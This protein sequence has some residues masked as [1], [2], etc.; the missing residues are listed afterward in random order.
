MQGSF[1]LT[2]VIPTY[3]RAHLIEDTLKSVLNQ[4][5]SDFEVWIIDDGSTDNTAE[6]VSTYLSDRIH[7]HRIENSERGVARNTGTK[8]AKGNYINWLD[9]DDLLLPNHVSEIKQAVIQKHFPDVLVFDYK[10]YFTSIQSYSKSHT[11]PSQINISSKELIKGNFFSCN[12]V[13]VKSAVALNN[14]FNEDRKLSASEDYELWLRLASKYPI[15]GVNIVT[16]V[17][18]HHPERSVFTMKQLDQLENRFN[19]FIDSISNNEDV[20][21]FISDKLGYF[22]MRNYLILAVDL[23]SKGHRAKARKY[24][25]KAFKNSKRVVFQRVF[26]ATLKHLVF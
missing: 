14:L 12:S 2:I 23:A 7:C 1:F 17:I 15:I 13:I 21:L 9:S 22:R 18:V 19:T 25:V 4:D 24:V 5:C 10:N 11:P 6:I 8:K 3:N 20:T 16:S 26:W